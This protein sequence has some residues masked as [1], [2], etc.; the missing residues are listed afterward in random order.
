[1][2]KRFQYIINY[3]SSGSL[4]EERVDAM[5]ESAK[6]YFRKLTLTNPSAS[7]LR[8]RA[9]KLYRMGADVYNHWFIEENVE[10]QCDGFLRELVD[11]LNRFIFYR[12]KNAA[13][14]FMPRETVGLLLKVQSIIDCSRNV[15]DYTLKVRRFCIALLSHLL[16][17]SS[18]EMGIYL[19]GVEI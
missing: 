17:E 10:E 1:M 6:N 11:Y 18:S 15:N 4:N 2:R 8:S 3:T 14:D 13:P 12:F 19:C 5:P 16:E 9:L 7:R